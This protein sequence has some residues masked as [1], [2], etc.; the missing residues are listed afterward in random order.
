MMFRTLRRALTGLAVLSLTALGSQPLFAQ[1]LP[2]HGTATSSA[3]LWWITQLGLGGAGEFQISNG[4][5][6]SPAL[7]ATTNGSGPALRATAGSGLAGQFDG[8]VL[9]SGFQLS[10]SPTNG[11]VLTSDASGNGAW[12]PTGLTL[13]FNGSGIVSGSPLFSINDQSSNGAAIEGFSNGFVGVVGGSSGSGTGGEFVS[14]GS[15][16]GMDASSD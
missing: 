14:D 4:S 11:Y 16:I 12:K 1:S 9:M 6:S 2:H 8:K 10:T 5:N 3:T 13:P 7:L 15:G